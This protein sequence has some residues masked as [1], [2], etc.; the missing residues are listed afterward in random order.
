M[1]L[2][3]RALTDMQS[4]MGGRGGEVGRIWR[5]T[6]AVNKTEGRKGLKKGELSLPS[7]AAVHMLK[8]PPFTA[9]QLLVLLLASAAWSSRS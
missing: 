3:G 2:Q 9:F 6:Q 5:A 8:R 1:R 7:G 4:A